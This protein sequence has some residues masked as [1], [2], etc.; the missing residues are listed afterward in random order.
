[1]PAPTRPCHPPSDCPAIAPRPGNPPRSR[2]HP[3]R[4]SLEISRARAPR[5]PCLC[6]RASKSGVP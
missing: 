5:D 1:L 3:D 4:H 2:A 6:R